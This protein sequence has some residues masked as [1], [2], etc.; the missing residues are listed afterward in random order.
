MKVP[1][2]KLFKCYLLVSKKYIYI[3]ICKIYIWNIYTLVNKA[4]HHRKTR[5]LCVG[6]RC[7][8][9]CSLWAL[10][11]RGRLSE[12]RGKG[13]IPGRWKGVNHTHMWDWG[14]RWPSEVYT[15]RVF[16]GESVLH[17]RW[18]KYWS[19]SFSTG[20]S[21]E[22]SGLI[23]FRIDWFDLLAVQG[24]LNTTVQKHQFFSA[25]PSL[26][27]NSHIC[28]WLLEKNHSFDYTELFCEC[29]VKFTS[30]AIWSR[31]FVCWEL[32]FVFF[33]NYQF[34]FI[35]DNWFVCIF[36]FFL[37]QYWGI[38]YFSRKVFISS[39][40]FILLVYSCF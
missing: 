31:T 36:Y 13:V 3:H 5:S 26:W 21:N 34:N 24:T 23:S 4:L 2:E 15:I 35:T 33:C 7:Q 29:L 30:E 38:V 19:F 22:Y 32:F 20:F 17:I 16:S 39:G 14:S 37:I 40:L 10:T 8:K 28:T 18:P 25:Q 9:S 11:G 27:S 6:R 12:S 1:Y